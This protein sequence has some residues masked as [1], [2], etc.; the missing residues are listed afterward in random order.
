[1]EE[2]RHV[3]ETEGDLEIAERQLASNMKSLEVMLEQ[4]SENEKLQLFLAE[5]FSLFALAFVEDKYKNS[6]E[7]F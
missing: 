1:M 6:I 4:D 7:K 3:F 2:S 5:T